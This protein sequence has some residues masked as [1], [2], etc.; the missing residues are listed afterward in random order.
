MSVLIHCVDK[1]KDMEAELLNH[2]KGVFLEVILQTVKI[3]M[4]YD[5]KHQIYVGSM[6]GLEFTV[7]EVDIEDTSFSD[8]RRGR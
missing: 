5:K 1:D 6:A 8:Y 7:K 2:R 3:R 4:A